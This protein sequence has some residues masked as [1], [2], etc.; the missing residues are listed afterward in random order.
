MIKM[1]NAE[2]LSKFPVVQHFPFGSLFSWDQDPD[3]PPAETSV[4]SSHQPTNRPHQQQETTR[5]PWA[6]P[7]GAMPPTAAPWSPTSSKAPPPGIPF[8]RAPWAGAT[9]LAPTTPPTGAP[10]NGTFDG[11]TKAP[12]A[13]DQTQ[14]EQNGKR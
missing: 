11:P 2:V 1:Y 4:H 12:W 5:A 8:T 3:A 9:P 13:K 6:A 10:Q 7:P 14:D